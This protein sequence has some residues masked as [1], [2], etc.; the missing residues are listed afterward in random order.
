M[1]RVIRAAL[2]FTLAAGV[3]ASAQSYEPLKSYHFAN[4]QDFEKYEQDIV[5]TADW[6]QQTP[7]AVQG[8]R[9]EKANQF[10]LD[11]A[12]GSPVVLIELKQAI[13][14]LSDANPQLGFVYMAQYS[15]YTIQHKNNFDKISA[16]MAALKAVMA[17]YIA[18]PTHNPD[19]DV[20]QLIQLDKQSKLEYWIENEFAFN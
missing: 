5:K 7:W 18:E 16:N 13:M 19:K 4:N 3:K 9:A 17:K 11:W 2:L 15:K 6:L 10:V 14:D 12:Q 20:E 1:K 8:A